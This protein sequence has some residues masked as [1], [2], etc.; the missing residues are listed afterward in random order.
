VNLV[1][2]FSTRILET[3]LASG[4][5]TATW[6]AAIASYRKPEVISLVFLG[7]S[8]GLPYLLVFATLT[9]WLRDEGVSRSAIGFFAWIGMMY[10]IK[11][12]WAPFVD[13]LKL[14]FLGERLGQRRSWMLLGQLGIVIALAGMSLVGAD[15]LGLLALL[16]LLV[17]FSSAT[18]DVAI[19]AYRIEIADVS[20]QAALSA[21]YIAGYR[22]AL[23]VSGAGALYAAEYL[24]WTAAY[25]VMATCGLVGVLTTLLI[26][27]P[28]ATVQGEAGVGWEKSW[29][30]WVVGLFVD[31]ITNFLQRN[32]QFALFILAFIAMY[33]L[34]DIT[35]G[36]MANPFYL[37]LG[38][39]K[40]EIANIAKG[41]GFGV[42]LFGSFLGGV[43]VLRFGLLPTLLTG[44]IL[45][46]T[47]N[48]L[49]ASL[50][51]FEPSLL[52]LAIIISADNLS[53]G[54]AATSFVAYLSSLTATAY[55]AT[56]YA[57]FSSLM[58][59]PG[60]FTSGFSGIIVDGLGYPTFFLLSGLFGL[61]A[62]LM[63]FYLLRREQQSVH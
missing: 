15:S 13:Q 45:V 20:Q 1:S 8:A 54:I 43:L 44:A 23:L 47:T 14:P 46:A 62:I 59:L 25:Q 41:L 34:S 61:P 7:F 52:G 50:A 42:S 18:Q 11:V 35:M 55:T 5:Q 53:G 24:G 10:S 37:D 2:H 56:Q 21:G 51:L 3:N 57:L 29:W 32:G 30:R 28:Q 31:P 16:A 40:L 58:T 38:F 9:A 33:R 6:R 39:T 48:I 26:K 60:K 12:V 36:V 27:Q 22:T 63:V 4:R 17:A 19:D 49:F